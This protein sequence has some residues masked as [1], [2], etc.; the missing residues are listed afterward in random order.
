MEQIKSNKSLL[1]YLI[2][3]IF[4]GAN[5]FGAIGFLIGFVKP[6]IFNSSVEPLWLWVSVL[7]LSGAA[8]G[9]VVGAVI[10][11]IVGFV[12][13]AYGLWKEH[14]INQYNDAKELVN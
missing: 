10:G 6:M 14:N 11:G 7:G 13:C 3:Y 4:G 1:L 9:I 8:L 2:G 5:I 12:M